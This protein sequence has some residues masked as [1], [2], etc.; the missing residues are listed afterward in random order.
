[1]TFADHFSAVAREYAGFRPSYPPALF[2][3]LAGQAPPHDLAWDCATGSG[4]AATDLAR[5]FARVIAT[6]ASAA[7]IAQS[8]P[9]RGVEYRVAPAEA[10]GLEAGSVDLIV[11]AQALH[12]FDQSRFNAEA[13]RVL[14]PGGAIAEWCYGLTTVDGA[15]VDDLVQHF[16]SEVVGPYWPAE[17]AH[18]EAGYRDLP[19]PFEPVA[20]PAFTMA[21][22]WTLA[23]LTG[24]LRTWSAT[25]RFVEARGHDP[26]LALERDL[27][28]HWGPPDGPRRVSWPLSL[29]VGRAGRC[30]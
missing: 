13:R 12:W 26:V 5:C 21:V 2:D 25:A 20:A 22:A 19:F 15:A 16:Y 1:M 7:Q 9:Q 23:Q 30:G 8:V 28:L 4:Q 6:D 18:I 14:K 24:Y 11:V 27:A 10:S 17:R 3:W 29:R